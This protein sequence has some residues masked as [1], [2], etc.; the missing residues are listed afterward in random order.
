MGKAQ[1]AQDAL[2]GAREVE[3]NLA[4][5]F[6]AGPPLHET[7]LDGALREL[8][9]AVVLDLQALGDGPDRGP[10]LRRQSSQNQEK[11]VLLRL[12]ARLTGSGLAE[13]QKPTDLVAELGQRLVLAIA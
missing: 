9:S 11:L 5:V 3:R 1:S 13:G 8:D 12:D 2:P 10:R 6:L 4:T 7:P